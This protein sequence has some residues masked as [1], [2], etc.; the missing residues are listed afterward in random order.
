MSQRHYIVFFLRPNSS[1]IRHLHTSCNLGLQVNST[2]IL[3]FSLLVSGKHKY[4]L[5]GLP[6]ADVKDSWSSDNHC[7]QFVFHAVLRDVLERPIPIV[8]V[9]F[10]E[11]LRTADD[12]VPGLLVEGHPHVVFAAYPGGYLHLKQTTSVFQTRSSGEDTRS[13]FY[14]FAFT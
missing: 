8:V 10:A 3:L 9:V 13:L 1:F 5:V 2:W 12:F 14:R 6:F 7:M 4:V 11:E